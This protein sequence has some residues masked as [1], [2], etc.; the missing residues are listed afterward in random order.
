[1]VRAELGNGQRDHAMALLYRVQERYVAFCSIHMWIP[2]TNSCLKSQFPPAV[3]ARISGI[4]LDGA[5]SPWSSL[6]VN[7]MDTSS[8]QHSPQWSVHWIVPSYAQF[9]TT[10]T[11][12]IFVT[13]DLFSRYYYSTS[14]ST[15]TLFYY[16][17]SYFLLSFFHLSDSNHGTI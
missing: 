4:M 17:L 2:V 12:N 8:G 13:L 3:Y 16:S 11:S 10:S 7:I 5:V 6:N 14:T 15:S 9:G 1:M